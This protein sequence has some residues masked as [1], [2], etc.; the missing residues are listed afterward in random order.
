MLAGILDRI[1]DTAISVRAVVAEFIGTAVFIAASTGTA[2]G[3]AELADAS[4]AVHA[5]GTAMAFGFTIVSMA[6]AVGHTSGGQM[7]PAVTAGL[8]LSGNLPALQGALNAASQVLGAVAGSAIVYG[9]FPGSGEHLTLAGNSVPDGVA[10]GRAYLGEL[11]G[12]FALVFV[13]LESACS[14]ASKAN[15]A[16]APVA[17]GYTVLVAHLLL[18]PFTSCSINPARSLGPAIVSGVWGRQFWVFI[19]A[20][21]TG[22]IA[23]VPAHLFLA[24]PDA[25]PEI[26]AC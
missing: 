26:E 7:N 3:L 10:A 8:V 14:A 23:A 15:R 22:A 18:I 1:K 11:V 2:V 6:Y 21:L 20:P 13:V 17:I 16:L 19:V 25:R 9:M 5:V 12:T 4:P 24:A